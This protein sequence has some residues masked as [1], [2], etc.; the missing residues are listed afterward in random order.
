VRRTSEWAK[1]SLAARACHTGSRSALFAIVQGGLS[2][3]LRE[4]S[5]RDLTALPFDGFAVGGLSVGE[6]SDAMHEAARFTLSLLPE[7]KPRYT[8]GLGLPHDLLR[9][10]ASGADMFDCV[11]PTRHARNAQLFTRA[12]VLRM[13]NRRYRTDPRPPDP[14]CAC[15]T[16]AHFSRAYLRHLFLAG[17]IL[18]SMLA[19]HHN[20]AFFRELVREARQAIVAGT[21]DAFLAQRLAESTEDDA[22]SAADE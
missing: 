6:P 9:A 1:R 7:E 21:L 10:I 5:A 22:E 3:A 15:T 19:T 13:R 2:H 20:L 8:M 18:A 17:E 14:S 16:C 11:V 4:Q 12:G